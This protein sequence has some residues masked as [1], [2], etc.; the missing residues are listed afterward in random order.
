MTAL[1][2]VYFEGQLGRAEAAKLVAEVCG[3]E[4]ESVHV[5]FSEVAA[6]KAKLPFGSFPLMEDGEYQL[7]QGVAIAQYVAQKAGKLVG[8]TPQEESKIMMMGLCAEDLRSVYFNAVFGDDAKKA[9]FV[10][11]SI[12]R[13]F[14]NFE[15]VLEGNKANGL[16]VVGSELTWGDIA[17]FDAVNHA[18]RLKG[19]ALEGYPS[20][21]AFY[22][23]I[24]ALPAINGRLT[25]RPQESRF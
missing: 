2:I 17:V 23:S 1:K 18:L 6:Y 11:T 4:Y 10:G 9:D 20:L 22:E 13:F 24:A 19:D 12:P 5:P 3:V 16:H 14:A 7:T 21:K 25:S 8:K 15:K